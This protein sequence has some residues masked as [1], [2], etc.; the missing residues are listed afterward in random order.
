[1][2]QFN[3]EWNQDSVINM[4]TDLFNSISSLGC[5]NQYLQFFSEKEYYFDSK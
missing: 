5:I 2:A 1:M 4:S 3:L